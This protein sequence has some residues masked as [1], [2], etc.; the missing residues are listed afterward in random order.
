MGPLTITTTREIPYHFAATS[1]IGIPWNKIPWFVT[2]K[3]WWTTITPNP[4]PLSCIVMFHHMFPMQFKTMLNKLIIMFSIIKNIEM[5]FY[6]NLKF[7]IKWIRCKVMAKTYMYYNWYLISMPMHTLYLVL[8]FK[9]IFLCK[10]HHIYHY[11]GWKMLDAFFEVLVFP[12]GLEVRF[13]K[14]CNFGFM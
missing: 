12:L 5:V 14:C 6:K 10:I 3:L 7:F 11:V 1:Q 13:T 9:C 4:M 8:H 2:F